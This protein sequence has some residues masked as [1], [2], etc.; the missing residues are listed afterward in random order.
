MVGTLIIDDLFGGDD[1]VVQTCHSRGRTY[2][3]AETGFDDGDFAMLANAFGVVDD[4]VI[5]QSRNV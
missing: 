4:V 2:V 5:V 1:T 3:V